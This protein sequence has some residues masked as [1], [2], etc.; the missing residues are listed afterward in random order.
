MISSTFD[1]K[2]HRS[3]AI[4]RNVILTIAGIGVIAGVLIAAKMMSSTAE[5]K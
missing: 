5:V 4:S 2:S 1:R 3:G